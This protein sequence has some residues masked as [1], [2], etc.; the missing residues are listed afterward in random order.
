MS[1]PKLYTTAQVAAITCMSKKTIQR[2]IAAGD[3]RATRLG[4]RLVR[5]SAHDLSDFLA[6]RKL[7]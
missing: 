1:D 6:G 3:L 2:R 5:I 4:P 7:A